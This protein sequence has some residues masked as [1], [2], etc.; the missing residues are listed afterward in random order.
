MTLNVGFTGHQRKLSKKSRFNRIFSSQAF[1]YY[2]HSKKTEEIGAKMLI[3]TERKHFENF[4]WNCTLPYASQLKCT[5]AKSTEI[6]RIKIWFWKLSKIFFSVIWSC[7]LHWSKENWRERM[8]KKKKKKKQS[9]QLPPSP[10]QTTQ[11]TPRET[12]TKTEELPY[13]KVTKGSP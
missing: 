9:H 2:F 12:T 1:V 11:P 4:I 7:Y 3:T 10:N 6:F 13:H 5:W 8:Q